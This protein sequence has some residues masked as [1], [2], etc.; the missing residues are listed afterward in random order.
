[1]SKLNQGEQPLVLDDEGVVR[2]RH[3]RIVRT[4]L[5]VG[6]MDMNALALMPFSDEERQIFAQ[7]IGYSVSGYGDLSYVDNEALERAD[8]AA[9]AFLEEQAD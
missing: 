9:D 2:F 6:P 1:M 4:L 3:N 8:D 7:L 5:D